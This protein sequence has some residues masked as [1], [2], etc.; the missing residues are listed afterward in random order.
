MTHWFEVFRYE[1]RQQFRRKSYLFMTFGVPLLA[2]LVFLAYQTYQ[3]A[4]EDEAD[5]PADVLSD[6]VN[7]SGGSI[8]GYV[9]E[10]PAGLFPAPETYETVECLP[11]EGESDSIDP[12]SGQQDIRSQLIKRISSP[13]CMRS[14]IVAFPDRDTGKSALEDGDVDV[15]YVVEPD[16][17]QSGDVTVYVSGINIENI[18][19]ESFFTDYLLRSALY[20]VDAAQY[21]PLYLR[22]RDPAFVVEHNITDTGAAEETN[23]DQNFILVYGFG[24]LIMLSTFWGG[25]Y[26]MQSVVQEKESR[27][28][29]IVL[30]S[31]RPT[32]LLAGK[33]LAMGLISIIQVGML[34][35][36]FVFIGSQAGA[37]SESLGDL[38]IKAGMVVVLVIYFVFGFLLLGSL[39]AVIGA[40]SPSVRESQN[41]VVFVTLPAAVP[42][43]FLT[44]FAEEP[45]STIPVIMSM[46]PFTAPISMVMRVAAADVPLSQLVLS[47]LLLVGG[48]VLAVWLAGRAFRVNTLLSG[49]MPKLK[50]IPRLL[51]G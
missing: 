22:L 36:A 17:A 44:V 3:N 33:I 21:E 50:D 42:F 29:E 16:Y 13:H 37:L 46:F 51:R 20:N 34:V 24:L 19:T 9:D 14:R 40:L 45:N 28:I 49:N 10:T 7:D 35:A 2:V 48:V 26:L 8:V 43:F 23:E 27:I 30:S 47:I 38:E 11:Q 25:G 39:M 31:V 5:K 32:A 4:A 15:L 41:F 18:D 1:L 12:A 6:T